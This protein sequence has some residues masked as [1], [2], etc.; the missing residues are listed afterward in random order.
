VLYRVTKEIGAS[1]FGVV[2]GVR[3][4]LGLEAAGSSLKQS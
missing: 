4:G 2:K 1:M 3:I